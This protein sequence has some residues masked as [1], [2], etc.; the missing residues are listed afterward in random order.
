MA[1]G[2]IKI[3]TLPTIVPYYSTVNYKLPP[4]K[5]QAPPSNFYYLEHLLGVSFKILRKG[6]T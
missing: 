6:Y 1:C 4:K 2:L 5:M 3:S